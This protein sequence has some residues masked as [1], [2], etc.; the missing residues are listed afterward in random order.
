MKFPASLTKTLASFDE[1]LDTLALSNQ[2]LGR[3]IAHMAQQVRSVD[4]DLDQRTD[5]V[6]A[7]VKSLSET[8][9]RIDTCTK[10]L[11]AF[12]RAST[13]HLFPS[14]SSADMRDKLSRVVGGHGC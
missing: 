1:K 8:L 4:M 10:G 12:D 5:A 14:F 11:Y 7:A 6:A 13:A 9:T 3:D 2:K